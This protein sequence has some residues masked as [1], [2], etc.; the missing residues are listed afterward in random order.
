MESHNKKLRL[1]MVI[2]L[3]FLYLFDTKAQDLNRLRDLWKAGRY[4]EVYPL[5]ARY[6]P[7]EKNEQTEVDY[8]F[9]TSL[10]RCSDPI[11]N[12]DCQAYFTLIL[13]GGNLDFEHKRIVEDEMRKCSSKTAPPLILVI[14]TQSSSAGISGTKMMASPDQPAVNTPAVVKRVIPDSVLAKRLF[15]GNQRIEGDKYFRKLMPDHIV[16]SDS[17][18]RIVSYRNFTPA[19]QKVMLDKLNCYLS[20]FLSKYHLTRPPFTITVYLE[21]SKDAVRKIAASLHGL[22]VSKMAIGYTYA[23]DYSI[24]AVSTGITI[25]PTAFHEL[26]HVVSNNSKGFLPAWLDEGVAA[27]YEWPN[28]K[29]CSDI[30][31]LDDWRGL[32]LKG[33]EG[34]FPVAPISGL[35]SMDWGEF[36][37]EAHEFGTEPQILNYA[38]ARYFMMYLDERGVLD[39][40][41]NKL[42]Q[43][44]TAYVKRYPNSF[45]VKILEEVCDNKAVKDIDN[46]FKQWMNQKFSIH[47]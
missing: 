8:L 25:S 39:K 35:V 22:E 10:C 30:S 36:N 13:K 31:G 29:S 40:Y 12:A 46:D 27:I 24:I 7:R 45:Q 17:G 38:L 19:Q 43:I 14:N 28:H 47:L 18:F 34:H 9:A 15:S 42:F 6:V 3:C 32:I 23:Q 20:F 21:G 4:D 5:L 16:F 41:F 11:A 26:F 1:L 2:S 44:D 33:N 37:N